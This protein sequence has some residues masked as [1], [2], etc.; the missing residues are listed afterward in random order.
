M[1][2]Q[3][4]KTAGVVLTRGR[5]DSFQVYWAQRPESAGFL[6]GFYSYFI[7]SLEAVDQNTPLDRD[8]DI[9]AVDRAYYA[10]ALRE[11]HEEA[12]LEFEASRLVLLG[13]WR[14]PSWLD[15]DFHTEF[16]WLHLNDE[17]CVQLDI[18][19]LPERVDR[20]EVARSEWIRPAAAI[21]RWATGQALMTTPLVAI[22][23]I[24]ANTSEDQRAGALDRC[25]ANQRADAPMEVAGGLRVLPL[26][27]VTLPPAT[28][29]N[30]FLVGEEAFVVIDP[31]S[32]DDA[33]LDV[34]FEAIDDLVG[35]GR[36]FEAVV[37]THHHRD[38]ISGVAAVVGRYGK[39]VWAHH[40]TA[41]RLDDLSIERELE[42]GEFIEL[43][44]D[45]LTCLHTPGHAP[46]HLCLFHERTNSVIVGDLIASKGTI[47]IDPPDGHVGDYMQSLRRIRDLE[48]RTLFPAHGW[49]VTTPGERLDFY[50]EHRWARERSTLEALRGADSPATPMDLVPEVYDD[51][52][53][54]VWPMA[55]RSLLA[56]L[57]HLVEQNIAHT[58]G[59][60]FWV[61]EE[62][63][64]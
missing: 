44:Q 23:N 27:T 10:A 61:T 63:S 42:D 22:L 1:Q 8:D 39:P 46:G 45:T 17:E 37:L 30:C 48:A 16:F 58:D 51:V 38:H 6:G 52:P 19:N 60:V 31:G 55:A 56:H 41:I 25:R 12:G 40:E 36:C 43:D 47:V 13:G 32:A 24:F 49:A 28:H 21:E 9:L 62:A 5:D 54:H 7:G 57:I 3:P 15:A 34:L 64:Y 4:I 59:T 11:L 29:T 50:I 33:E 53:K 2:L 18:D 14:T 20:K 35:Q 26:E